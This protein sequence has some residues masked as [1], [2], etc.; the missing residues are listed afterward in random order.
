MKLK[1]M[2]NSANSSYVQ[3]NL[4]F[5]AFNKQSFTIINFLGHLGVQIS[6]NF[7][8]GVKNYYLAAILEDLSKILSLFLN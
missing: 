8:I 1:I 7:A 5:T 4:G 3:L 2:E 6:L